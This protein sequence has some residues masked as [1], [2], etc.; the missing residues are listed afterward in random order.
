MS[1]ANYICVTRNADVSPD[2]EALEVTDDFRYLMQQTIHK[3]R[4]AVMTETATT[5]SE[6][7]QKYFRSRHPVEPDFLNKDADEIRLHF[8]VSVG[9]YRCR[10]RSSTYISHCHAEQWTCGSR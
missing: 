7:T 10:E 5:E 8:W 3:R 4:M 2:D 9:I 6:E 1:E